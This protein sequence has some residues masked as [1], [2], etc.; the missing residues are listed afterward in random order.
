MSIATGRNSNLSTQ[1]SSGKLAWV[2]QEGNDLFQGVLV[3]GVK[4]QIIDKA[5]PL[6]VYSGSLYTSFTC[7]DDTEF[8]AFRITMENESYGEYGNDYFVNTTMSAGISYQVS[9]PFTFHAEQTTN[10]Q[11]LLNV[12]ATFTGT[13]PTIT[14]NYIKMF[15]IV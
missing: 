2:V 8:T 13:A 4:Q 5:Y 10:D 3:S 9:F 15:K 6:G 14:Y 11:L 1:V 12:K 7:G